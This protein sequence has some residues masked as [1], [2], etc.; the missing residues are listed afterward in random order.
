MNLILLQNGLV[1]ANIKGDYDSRMGY[2]QF[3][4]M[5]QTKNKKEDF[6]MFVAE[7]EKQSLKRYLKIIGR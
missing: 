5:A 1:I 7:I 2:Y 3:L 4:E 6:L